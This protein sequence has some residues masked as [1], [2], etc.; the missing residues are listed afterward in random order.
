[1]A[2]GTPFTLSEGSQAFLGNARWALSF[3]L[4]VEPAL[5]FLLKV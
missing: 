5:Q 1:M 2:V 3:P 4:V